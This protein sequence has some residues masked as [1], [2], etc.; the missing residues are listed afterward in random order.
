M[1]SLIPRKQTRRIGSKGK[2][3]LLPPVID[4][5]RDQIL[6]LER[7]IRL[8]IQSGDGIESVHPLLLQIGQLTRASQRRLGGQL[9]D[10]YQVLDTLHRLG[11]PA[12]FHMGQENPFNG[13]AAYFGAL[14]QESINNATLQSGRPYGR[15][16][17]DWEGLNAERIR[18]GLDGIT[19]EDAFYGISTFNFDI[20]EMRRI[21]ASGVQVK[22][23]K[24]IFNLLKPS[25]QQ[26]YRH[27]ALNNVAKQLQRMVDPKKT[28]IGGT[29]PILIWDIETG[30]LSHNEGIR[31]MSGKLMDPQTGKI[32]KSKTW[33]VRNDLL[34]LAVVGKHSQ[35][36]NEYFKGKNAMSPDDAMA[37]LFEMAEEADYRMGG[38]NLSF[39]IGHLL[40]ARRGSK[41]KNDTLFR[42]RHQAFMEAT[43]DSEKFFDTALLGR[44]IRSDGGKVGMSN[45]ITET[46][47][48]ENI[49]KH[50]GVKIE[51]LIPKLARLHDSEVDT[52]FTAYLMHVMNKE[53]VGSLKES[54]LDEAT[55][56]RVK[57]AVAI[58]QAQPIAL[59]AP[60]KSLDLFDDRI[61][62]QVENAEYWD[63]LH[64]KYNRFFN[65]DGTMFNS[66]RGISAFEQTNILTR[67]MR[68]S[69]FATK[70]H[71]LTGRA[72]VEE[73]VA[74]QKHIDDLFR[75]YAPD[76]IL[77]SNNARR[78]G[79]KGG[80][81]TLL[82]RQKTI[83]DSNSFFSEMGV[84][85]R[86]ANA[87]LVRHNPLP[88][89]AGG[90]GLEA[91]SEAL[92]ISTIG[93]RVAKE[94][95]LMTLHTGNH[96]LALPMQFVDSVLDGTTAANPLEQDLFTLNQFRS[97]LYDEGKVVGRRS[98]FSLNMHIRDGYEEIN[99][100]LGVREGSQLARLRDAVRDYDATKLHE[101]GFHDDTVGDHKLTA[102]EKRQKWLDNLISKDTREFGIQ[103]GMIDD[104]SGEMEEHFN[105]IIGDVTSGAPRSQRLTVTVRRNRLVEEAM[106]PL[107]DSSG[108]SVMKD[109]I[110]I[111]GVSL[112]EPS[113]KHLEA[114]DESG[115]AAAGSV[116]AILDS[117]YTKGDRA[118]MKGRLST[119]KHRNNGEQATGWLGK[120][121]QGRD[122]S[123]VTIQ[124]YSKY[125]QQPMYRAMDFAKSHPKGL[126]LAV[127]AIGIGYYSHKKKNE[128]DDYYDTVR[129]MPYE[130]E[131]A[132]FDQSSEIDQATN[133]MRTA[134]IVGALDRNKSQH[135]KMGAGKNNHLFGV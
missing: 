60:L 128:D 99:N 79:L 100:V 18:Q 27:E 50:T 54:T 129:R 97:D 94:S 103:V 59:R 7:E 3:P 105:S 68:A 114:L 20:D 47:F 133:P 126:G 36:L 32:I 123:D 45:L 112:G 19:A 57:K 119:V 118:I 34:D 82:G 31:E 4:G 51:D 71:P 77:E 48:L 67:G 9:L 91:V 102:I 84:H 86:L 120:V 6:S 81:K 66:D 101:I 8:A 109:R 12:R 43:Q 89:T 37:E 28:L 11:A 65:E 93:T 75:D 30:G 56:E 61:R 25:V 72:A 17:F 96:I 35:T 115:R 87:V 80:I 107:L 122:L 49:Q 42:L 46:N 132:R 127:A 69:N 23:P 58:S 70:A 52:E 15:L 38:Q 10:Q 62:K 1:A 85:D 88:I 121:L 117:D 5:N 135:Y 2:T 130:E 125:V 55:M 33:N 110:A 95:S 106:A 131:G 53:G 78:L 74:S 39:D 22:N 134:G 104:I 41:Y 44:A 13:E 14:T 21:A 92:G 108:E 116:R 40:S 64:G 29:K 16:S 24:T 124:N 90:L 26:M 76:R 73:L 98:R 113:A 83:A 111:G 63:P